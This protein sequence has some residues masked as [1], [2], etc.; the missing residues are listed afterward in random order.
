M[1][2][3]TTE[4]YLIESSRLSKVPDLIKLPSGLDT[5]RLIYLSMTNS[6][7]PYI[8]Y[9]LERSSLQKKTLEKYSSRYGSERML[10]GAV[11]LEFD[12]L[13]KTM[14]SEE[15]SFIPLKGSVL[16][17]LLYPER[18]LRS[19]MDIDILAR[20]EDCERLAEL[21]KRINYSQDY[22]GTAFKR[23]ILPRMK[24]PAVMNHIEDVKFRREHSFLEVHFKLLS[25]KIRHQPGND[26]LWK[27]SKSFNINGK[28][29][30]SLCCEHQLIN[31]A[32]HS[33]QHSFAFGLRPL[34]EIDAL[35]KLY[36]KELNWDKFLKDVS[37]FSLESLIYTPLA[38]SSHFYGSDTPSCVLKELQERSST[39]VTK[40]TETL[41]PD[42]FNRHKIPLLKNNSLFMQIISQKSRIR[43]MSSL[44]FPHPRV[45]LLYEAEGK[46]GFLFLV[47]RYIS[48]FFRLIK[49]Y[50]PAVLKDIINS[51]KLLYGK[52]DRVQRG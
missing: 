18:S 42:F 6:V 29:I 52:N 16:S 31:I 30:N 13:H 49:G 28:V 24:D 17:S 19:M 43:A 3:D 5:D 33:T 40:L 23:E 38:L 25:S 7:F 50:L 46:K 48:R 4:K 22:E 47:S 8:Y 20:Y 11:H 34:S 45:M 39:I 15:I 41:K 35:L 14:S 12:F 27:N 44:F 26:D 2:Y 32:T 10:S 1:A 36:Q 51:F 21:L 37:R 9:L